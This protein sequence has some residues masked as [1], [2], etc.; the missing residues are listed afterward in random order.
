M[1]GVFKMVKENKEVLDTVEVIYGHNENEIREAE[2]LLAIAKEISGYGK[3]ISENNEKEI[4]LEDSFTFD[5][6]DESN[7]IKEYYDNRNANRE[8]SSIRDD[9]MYTDSYY[10]LNRIRQ[11]RGLTEKLERLQKLIKDAVFNQTTYMDGKHIQVHFVAV[12][13]SKDESGIKILVAKRTTMRKKLEGKWEFGC[14]K[15][16]MG[17]N[18]AQKIANEYKKDFNI[19]INPIMDNMR[20]MK[21]PIPIALYHVPRKANIKGND[22][23]IIT[24]AE[25]KGSF[26]PEDFKPTSKHEKVKWV[27]E[28]DLSKL[29]SEFQECV[30]DFKQTLK[31]AFEKIKSL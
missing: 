7:L 9:K 4:L 1:V 21:E 10:A 2:R 31:K 20:E 15:I 22:I 14:A 8:K 5:A 23:G 13:F 6:C 16:V 12:C 25:I 30:P 26:N 24:I 29:E 11:D 3:K 18:I 19:E 17:D 27:T 28:E